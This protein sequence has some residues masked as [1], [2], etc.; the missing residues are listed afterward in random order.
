MKLDEITLQYI[1]FEKTMGDYL[2]LNDEEI[3]ELAKEIDIKPEML[4]GKGLLK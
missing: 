4:K 3:E 2:N 1:S